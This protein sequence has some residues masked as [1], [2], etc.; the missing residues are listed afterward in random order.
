MARRG[1]NCTLS[2]SDGSARHVYQVR[3]SA[4]TYGYQMIAEEGQARVT[5]AYYPHQTAPTQFSLRVDLIG[6]AER[7]SFNAYLMSYVNYA[8]DPGVTGTNMPQVTVTL[9][10]RNFKRVGVPISGFEFGGH[11]GAM[12]FQPTVVFE[13]SGEP[14]DWNEKILPSLVKIGNSQKQSPETQYFYPTGTQLNG[15]DSPTA[16]GGVTVQQ[17]VNGDGYYVKGGSG[18]AAKPVPDMEG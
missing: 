5:R 12:S 8:L 1:L 2:Y 18:Y 6:Y 17:A 10:A 13:T 14:L 3:C 9:P 15:G 7:N 11:L 16:P 4:L